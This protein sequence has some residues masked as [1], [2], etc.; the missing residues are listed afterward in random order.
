MALLNWLVCQLAFLFLGAFAIYWLQNREFF[1]HLLE[2]YG[3]HLTLIVS[4][5]PSTVALLGAGHALLQVIVASLAWWRIH[6]VA[7]AINFRH[8]ELGHSSHSQK[9]LLHF[10]YNGWWIPVRASLAANVSLPEH[11]YIQIFQLLFHWLYLSWLINQVY[12]LI[13]MENTMKTSESSTNISRNCW[14]L[15]AFTRSSM[16][17]V[18]TMPSSMLFTAIW[19]LLNL[20]TWVILLS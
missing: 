17:F 7:G 2:N 12:S 14:D 8:V 3:Y 20:K 9:K 18:G 5:L 19:F 6:I 10:V 16:V 4:C 15:G 13:R 1:S 11:M